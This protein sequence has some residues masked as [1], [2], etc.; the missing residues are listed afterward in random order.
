MR[1]DS[2]SGVSKLTNLLTEQRLGVMASDSGT[3]PYVSLVA[4][5]VTPDLNRLIF[6]TQRGT[7]KFSNIVAYPQVSMLIDNR[8]NQASD[9]VRGVAVTALGIATEVLGDA[10]KPLLQLFLTKHPEL[11]SFAD[12]PDT[13]V[14]EIAVSRY[15]MVS[16]F[17]KVQIFDRE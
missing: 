12:A 4:F 17:E 14:I 1:S 3:G 5:A 8:T 10:K 2:Q 16:K 9:L 7:H 13:A 11:C 6:L 15:I